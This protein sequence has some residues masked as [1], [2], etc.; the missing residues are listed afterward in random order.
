MLYLE[1]K[2]VKIAFQLLDDGEMIP[3][4]SKK[5][6]YHIIFDV[7][8]NLTRKARLVA[9]GHK[10]KEVKKQNTY[11]SVA[12]RDS[13]RICLL[14]AALNDLDVM[15]T[16]IGNAYLNAKCKERVHVK[17]GLELFGSEHE[18]KIAVIVRT[19]YGLKTAGNN[20]RN[21]LSSV[22]CEE[23]TY[24]PTVVDPDVYRKAEAT[25]D[26]REYYSYMVLYVD[27]I[28]SIHENPKIILD[29]LGTMFRLKNGI[30]EPKLYLGADLK[31]WEYQKTD[32]TTGKCWAVGSSSYFKEAIKI[33]ESQMEQN[34]LNEKKRSSDSI[35]FGRLASWIMS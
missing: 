14:L 7:K 12:S 5:I 8:F 11:S 23:L 3:S 33:A 1:L 18:G 22:I 17:C 24:Q 4:G 15:M 28:P 9:G 32:G 13:V 29:K 21:H 34:N 35:Q 27:D 16:D 30:E 25:S 10:N 19:L 6:P 26:G 2:N 31:K 20:W